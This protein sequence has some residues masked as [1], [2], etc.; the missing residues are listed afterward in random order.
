M[1]VF[2]K[3]T[4]NEALNTLGI[5][6]DCATKEM[7]KTSYRRLA[8]KYHPDRNPEGHAVMQRVNVA[9]TFLSSC[10][11]LPDDIRPSRPSRS[12]RRSSKGIK[13]DGMVIDKRNGKTIVSGK[14]FHSREV[15]KKCGF[16][17][18]QEDKIW[19]CYGTYSIEDYLGY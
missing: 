1:D 14:T 18:S 12:R 2:M 4:I 17:W 8:S 6:R 5:R 13:I 11:G 3:M 16:K 19:W 7:I 15:L 10:K 9:Y